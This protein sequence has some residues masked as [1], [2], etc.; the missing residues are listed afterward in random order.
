[1]NTP[2]EVKFSLKD[3]LFNP[4]KVAKIAHEIHRVYPAFKRLDFIEAVTQ[5][6]PELELKER[7]YHITACLI[8]FLPEAYEEAIAILL[9]SLP[10]PCDP[11]LKDNDFGD[12]I[13]APYNHFVVVKGCAKQQLTLSL[14]A[15]EE[16]TT[17]FSAEDAIRYFINAFPKESLNQLKKWVTHPHYHVRRLVSEGTRPKLP[18]SQNIILSPK[19]SIPFLNQLYTDPT[20][21]VTRSVANHLNDIS[22]I[23]PTLVFELLANWKNEK[24][25]SKK[26]LDYIIRH[27]LRTCIKKG[28]KK[29]LALIGVNEKP[30]LSIDSSV[31]SKQVVMDDY[32]SFDIALTPK[33]DTTLLIDYVIHFQSKNGDLNRKKVF[34]LKQMDAKA[35]ATIQLS[36]KQHMRKNMS[37]RTLYPGTHVWQLQVNGDIV[38]E[39]S[40][41]LI[42]N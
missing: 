23:E 7:I 33:E 39:E 3:Q 19:E 6:F 8:D 26:E 4:T 37:T 21:Y 34:K 20:R 36:K 27:A 25:Q 32:F 41:E 35:N 5:K 1:M 24:K 16:L 42:S 10:Q 13:Y 12:Y 14:N 30:L 22:K 28:D 29:A 9:Q 38:L 40:F 15:L 31:I 11:K 17:R 18:W 2:L